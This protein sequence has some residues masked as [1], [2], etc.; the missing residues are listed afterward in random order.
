MAVGVMHQ[1]PVILSDAKDL[2]ENL[3]YSQYQTN[4]H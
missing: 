1:S 4:K 2:V 3:Q